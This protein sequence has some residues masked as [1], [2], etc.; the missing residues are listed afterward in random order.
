MSSFV[1]YQVFGSKSSV[2]LDV[3]F[4]VERIGSVV[5][6][7]EMLRYLISNSTFKQKKKVNGNLAVIE[8]GAL[9]DCFKGTPDEL[10]NSLFYTYHLHDQLH[11]QRITKLLERNLDLKLVR[12]M[13]TLVSYFTR[14]HKRTEAKA[15]LHG[16]FKSKIDFI[17]SIAL[18]DFDDF[19][20]NGT[21]VEVYK[22]MAFQMG[23]VLALMKGTEVY[24]KEA[25]VAEFPCLKSYLYREEASSNELQLI[26]NELMG[27]SLEYLPLM[28][29]AKEPKNKSLI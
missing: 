28:S 2:D 5:E 24:T 7:N 29:L 8:K 10:N 23:Q 26:L 6:N 25:V 3:C 19:G 4:F 15:A 21:V 13:R 9:I 11:E 14:T 1:S 18:E 16:Y 27:K 12:C 17:Q 22:S 20:K